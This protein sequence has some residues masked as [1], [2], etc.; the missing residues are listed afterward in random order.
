MYTSFCIYLK[1]TR[2]LTYVSS[3]VTFNFENI[4]FCVYFL[5]IFFLGVCQQ[6]PL[7][8]KLFYILIQ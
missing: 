6:K 8:T 5:R 3:M 2:I 1:L 7:P 4:K